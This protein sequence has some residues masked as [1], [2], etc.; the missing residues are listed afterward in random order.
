[1][2]PFDN[3]ARDGKR[4]IVHQDADIS[5]TC[6]SCGEPSD[7]RPI[8]CPPRMDKSGV[9]HHTPLMNLPWWFYLIECLLYFLFFFID[10]PASRRRKLT[11]GL[12]RTHRRKRL[13]M[14][15]GS[16]LGAIAGLL[17]LGI[18]YIDLCRASGND[19]GSRIAHLR[20]VSLCLRSRPKA[21][22]QRRRF[23]LD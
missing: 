5:R 7:G 14:L 19:S 16:P 20:M 23:S 12:C 8:V 22:R 10:L 9:F 13:L 11:Y 17:L 21:Q 15:L 3:V 6:L 2:Q 18:A 1:M 4:L